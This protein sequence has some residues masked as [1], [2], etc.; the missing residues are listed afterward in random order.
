MVVADFSLDP[1]N[2][3]GRRVIHVYFGSNRRYIDNEPNAEPEIPALAFEARGFHSLITDRQRNSYDDRVSAIE[4]QFD[5]DV[6]LPGLAEAVVLPSV[7]LDDP[8]IKAKFAEWGAQP[9]PYD[10]VARF[11]PVE[12]VSQIRTLIRDYLIGKGYLD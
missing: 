2:D 9:L 12:Y 7:L 1:G 8:A 6:P 11:K 4:V 3:S 10:L 5:R